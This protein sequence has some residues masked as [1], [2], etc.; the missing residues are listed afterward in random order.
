MLLEQGVNPTVRNTDGHL[1]ME[2]VI[3]FGHVDLT[4]ML[5]AKF[6]CVLVKSISTLRPVSVFAVSAPFFAVRSVGYRLALTQK[7]FS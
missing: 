3:R 2:V 6:V 1:P 5:K 4:M 7:E